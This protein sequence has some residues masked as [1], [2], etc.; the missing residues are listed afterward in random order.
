MSMGMFYA[1]D[2]EDASANA[3]VGT[4]R[5]SCDSFGLQKGID[6]ACGCGLQLLCCHCQHHCF[7]DVDTLSY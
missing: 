5:T 7:C 3:D 2:E 6:S 1:C 4:I